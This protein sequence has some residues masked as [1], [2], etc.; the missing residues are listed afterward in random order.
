M[1]NQCEAL[2]FCRPNWDGP[3]CASEQTERVNGRFLCWVHR[4]SLQHSAPRDH[5]PMQFVPQ[6][7]HGAK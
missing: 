1:K 4:Y 3:R 6:Q 7:L 5:A 2:I